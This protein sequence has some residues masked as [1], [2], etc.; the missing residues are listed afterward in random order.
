VRSRGDHLL[1]DGG[2]KR[3]TREREEGREAAQENS[4][5]KQKKITTSSPRATSLP[6]VRG[7]KV[8]CHQKKEGNAGGGKGS[9]GCILFEKERKKK[10]NP[11]CCRRGKKVASLLARG[12]QSI[13]GDDKGAKSVTQDRSDRSFLARCFQQESARPLAKRK[14]SF[15]EGSKKVHVL[16]KVEPAVSALVYQEGRRPGRGGIQGGRRQSPQPTQGKEAVIHVR[17]VKVVCWV[18]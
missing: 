11:P 7:G 8:D 5:T 4:S 15:C 14:E 9:M 6:P 10:G 2:R 1:Y 16:K 3:G 12:H 17:R 18:P 13:P